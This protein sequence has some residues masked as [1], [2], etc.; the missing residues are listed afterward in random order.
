MTN[1][2]LY[3]QRMQKTCYSLQRFGYS[4]VMIVRNKF[5]KPSKWPFDTLYISTFFKRGKAFYIEYNLRLFFKLLPLK[6]KAVTAVDTDALLFSSLLARI[7]KFALVYDAHEYFSE[8]E[9]VVQ[10]P[11]TRWVWKKVED[12]C[13]PTTDARYTVSQGISKKLHALYN[14]EFQ[15]I[16][17]SPILDA[18][19]NLDLPRSY[20]LYQGAVNFGRGLEVLLHAMTHIDAKLVICGEGD[21]LNT[22]K[23]LANQL[24]IREKIEF[25]GYIPPKELK[26]ITLRAKIG[27]T[28]FSNH[29]QSNHY[30]L[31]NRFFDYFHAATPQLV[32]DYPEYK[33]FLKRYRVGVTIATLEQSEIADKLSL[34]LNNKSLYAELKEQCLLARQ[35]V[36]WQNQE[37]RL[38][39]IYQ[40]LVG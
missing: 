17:N 32:V 39:K 34:L 37:Q 27:I 9:E 12:L 10:R 40:S 22:L 7:K 18:D 8:L 19:L 28:F 31:S 38:K 2:L 25:K 11:F 14:K 4:I 5:N 35:D 6:A 21:A 36:H 16:E 15:V 33:Q 23:Q 30:S 29:G 1:D 24:R 20:I 3:D 13:I 26:A